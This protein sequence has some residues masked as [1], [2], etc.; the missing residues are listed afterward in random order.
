MDGSAL[1]RREELLSE[2]RR[3]P[4]GMTS[5]ELAETLGVDDSTIR[6]DLMRLRAGDLGLQRRGRRYRL[7][8]H[9]A[10]RPLRLKVDE[11]MALYLA[12]RLLARQQGDRNTHAESAMRKL[13]EAVDDDAP[14]L[15]RQFE[16]A[17]LVALALPLREGF[18]R[19]LE[20]LT[21][22]VS[23]GRVI[24]LQYRNQ[25]GKVTQRRFRPYALEPF[26][27]THACYAIGFDESVEAIRTF[28]VDRIE[29]IEVT[30]ERFE[31]PADFDPSRL[32]AEAWGVVWSGAEPT[33]VVLR[34]TGQSANVVRERIWHPSQRVERDA[35]DGWLMTFRVS[36]PRE[37]KRWV[38]Q[39][40]ADV[41]VIAPLDLREEVARESQRL[42][43]RYNDLGEI[44]PDADG[45]VDRP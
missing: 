42:G 3:H 45:A 27:E 4:D 30:G 43:S 16:D 32:F 34:F 7:D 40:G 33:R 20:I 18:Q 10:E 24:S 41:E 31:P 11:V 9:R 13:A 37:L 44:N 28:R 39:W 22:A 29:S 35:G 36:A 6:R 25:D 15:A 19:A 21:Q 17:A 12:C 1:S 38:L 2:L 26:G 14:R 5:R 8:F 23:D